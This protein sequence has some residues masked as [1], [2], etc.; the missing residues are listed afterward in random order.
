MKS[1]NP[2]DTISIVNIHVS[3]VYTIMFINN[4]NSWICVFSLHALIQF[5]D[6]WNQVWN[7]F[8]QE[9]KRPFFKR[10]SK[11]GM[12]C[13]S[14]HILNDIDCFI[15]RNTTFCQKTNHL[16]NDHR[17]VCIVDLDNSIVSQVIKIATFFNRFINNQLCTI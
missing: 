12:V 3:H 15:K 4:L 6:N 7:N 10:F 9:F 11:N 16:W 5:F 8:F 17:W 1:S 13:I 14:R 2:I